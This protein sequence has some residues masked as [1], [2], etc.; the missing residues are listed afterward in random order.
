V[1]KAGNRI[2]VLVGGDVRSGNVRELKE[3]TGACWFH[4]SAI[5]GKDTGEVAS[6]AEITSLTETLDS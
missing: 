2:E 5:V 3:V 1:E 4:S 6:A